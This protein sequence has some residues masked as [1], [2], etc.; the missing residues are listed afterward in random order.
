[1]EVES[2]SSVIEDET[3]MKTNR[4][5]CIAQAKRL[6]RASS[7]FDMPLDD[8]LGIVPKEDEASVRE[9][10]DK[11]VQLV[12]NH[13][14]RSV[15]KSFEDE[16]VGDLLKS[17]GTKLRQSKLSEEALANVSKTIE[18]GNLVKENE[19]NTVSSK[20]KE[21]NDYTKLLND[22]SDNWKKLISNRKDMVRNAE[23]N[24]QSVS[25]GDIVV[26]DD[27][28]YSLTAKEKQTL[29]MSPEIKNAIRQLEEHEDIMKVQ[30]MAFGQKTAKLKSSLLNDQQNLQDASKSLIMRANKAG[31]QIDDLMVDPNA[32]FQSNHIESF[33]LNGK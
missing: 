32:W 24:A 28:K 7:T 21:V 33:S 9:R 2:S 19:A 15:S 5:S 1:M 16:E 14:V 3:I 26:T 6:S 12:L 18:N 10:L 30:I 13:T 4:R 23:K 29:N 22:E 11:V 17:V 25:K 20:W 31:E 27:Q 8:L